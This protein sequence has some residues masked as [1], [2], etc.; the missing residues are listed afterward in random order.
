[1]LE[2]APF[3]VLVVDDDPDTRA[4]LR[5]ILD[6]DRYPVVEAASVADALARDDWSRYGAVVLDRQLPDGTA[7][8]LLPHL[9]RLAPDAAV[10]IVTGFDDLHGAVA[11][12]R[13]GAADY[14]LKPVNADEL[15][16]RFGRLV[17]ARRY[18]DAL[19]ES[20][21]FARAVLDSLSAHI[22]VL[23]RAGAVVAVNAAWDAFAR[24]RQG[25]PDRCGVG[26]NYLEVCRRASGP[27]AEEAPVVAA[28]IRDVLAGVLPR[29]VLE[30]PCDF[31]DQKMWFAMIVTPL[32]PDR[33][34]VVV[35]HLD[36]SDRKRAEEDLR[37]KSEELRA[38]TQQLW[39]AAR[40][41]GV[42]ELAAS[43]AHE[44]NNPLA[45]VHLRVEGLLAKTPPGDPRRRPLEV[46]DQEVTRMAGL[47][48]NL[49]GFSRAGRDQV[50]T[51]DVCEEVT[52]TAE[53]AAQHLRKRQIRFQPEFT[54]AGQV[55]YA[56]RQQ[57]RQ[58]FLNL[59]T[60]AA[61]AMPSGGRLTV[62]VA[63][64]TLPGGRAAVVVDV[65]DTGSGIPPEHLTRV[66]D[67]FFTTKEEGKG[68]GLGLAICRRIV[69][70]HNGALEI[71]SRVGAGT[72]VR[73][74]LPVRPD[75]NVAPLRPA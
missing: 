19:R 4:N 35:S 1:M 56:D 22:A 21:E 42:G 12:F 20:Q 38:T 36:I 73:V 11:A 34:G 40:L 63:P 46:V 32:G 51:V 57:L 17:E 50:S 66:L 9:R 49:L 29:F 68:T 44:L 43:L 58:V 53:L 7:E 8:D 15:R 67:P 62:R 37:A 69:E 30:Y 2:P 24:E 72:T 60:N 70:Q 26:A 5:D 31:V 45:T 28:G 74:T 39:Q 3:T 71:D 25:D 64:G 6:L 48:G 23:D 75:T 10:V 54:P 47:V 41:A 52:R 27:F 55:I 16:T 61:D 33:R 65:A 18:R 13:L 14:V 59:F